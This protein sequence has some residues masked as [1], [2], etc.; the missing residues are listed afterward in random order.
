F[1]Q[2]KALTEGHA[3]H[4]SHTLEYGLMAVSVVGALVAIIIAWNKFSKYQK[5]DRQ[6]VG[7]GKIV[8]NK[9]YVDELYNTIVVKPLLVIS[10]F[11]NGVIEKSGIDGF[12][13][14]VGK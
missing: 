5:S 3:H 11:F 9:W 6:E 10:K 4:L 7:L 2:S 13:N 14:G 12:V 8:E 1:A